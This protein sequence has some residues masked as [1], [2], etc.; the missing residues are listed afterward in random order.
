MAETLTPARSTVAGRVTIA[1]RVVA[2]VA[3]YAAGR[4]STPVHRSVVGADLPHV[5][6]DVAGRRVRVTARVAGSW[7]E[8]AAALAS[9]VAGAVRSSLEEIVGVQV[10]DVLVVVEAVV[11]APEQPRRV[12]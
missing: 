5:D 12:S 2:R 7:P 4:T 3:R 9:R 1:D 8:P 10:D 11:A 6:V